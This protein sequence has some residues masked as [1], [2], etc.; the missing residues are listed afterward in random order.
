M[1][2]LASPE[3][4]ERMSAERLRRVV[5]RMNDGKPSRLLVDGGFEILRAALDMD[6]ER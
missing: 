2:A 6:A 5:E 3:R 1:R 4:I